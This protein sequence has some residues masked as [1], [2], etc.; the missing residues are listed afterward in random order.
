[1]PSSLAA[2]SSSCC[3]GGS[4]GGERGRCLVIDTGK[5]D[6]RRGC[7]IERS[8]SRAERRWQPEEHEQCRDGGIGMGGAW[9]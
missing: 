3:G 9:E 1:M 8:E 7:S 6:A 5:R 2:R 4:R